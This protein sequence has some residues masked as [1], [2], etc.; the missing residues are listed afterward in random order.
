MALSDVERNILIQARDAVRKCEH[1]FICYAIDKAEASGYRLDE[2]RKAKTRLLWYIHNALG[3]NATLGG[4][5]AKKYGNHWFNDYDLQRKAR[6]AW[7]DWI[8][9]EEPVFDRKTRKLLQ[10]RMKP[11]GMGK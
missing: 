10:T 7:I 11:L 5:L 2:V 4:W 6:I 9:G 8:L 3:V 1:T